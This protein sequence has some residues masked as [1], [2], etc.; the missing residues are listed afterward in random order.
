MEWLAVIV[1]CGALSCQ[2]L[3][4]P[5]A[6]EAVCRV[7]LADAAAVLQAAGDA[8]GGPLLF[9]LSC[10]QAGDPAPEA[11]APTPVVPPVPRPEGLPA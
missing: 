5:V 11:P 7:V 3:S 10:D 4:W 1:V 6:S 8:G 2:Q 9:V